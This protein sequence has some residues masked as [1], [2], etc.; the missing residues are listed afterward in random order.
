[1]TP[2]GVASAMVGQVVVLAH[3]KEEPHP[4][5]EPHDHE[6]H[7]DDEHGD[8][9]HGDDVTSNNSRTVYV[10]TDSGVVE[11]PD[12]VLRYASTGDIVQASISPQGALES[13]DVLVPGPDSGI[14][15]SD[16]IA[17]GKKRTVHTVVMSPP[18]VTVPA[19]AVTNAKNAVT[20]AGQYWSTQ[21]N[22][23]MS[24]VHGKVINGSGGLTGG[25]NRSQPWAAWT[26]AWDLFG[27]T[28]ADLNS[29]NNASHLL[30]V[31]HGCGEGSP[32]GTASMGDT[33]I[34]SGGKDFNL[35]YT[36]A[37]NGPQMGVIA[38]ELGHNF[39][40]EHANVLE[41]GSG[42]MDARTD[43]AWKHHSGRCVIREYGDML[44]VM[45]SSG[46]TNLGS[47]SAPAADYLGFS[48]GW[49]KVTPGSKPVTLTLT[50]TAESSGTRGVRVTDPVTGDKYWL[51][52]RNNAG[53]DKSLNGR[54]VSWGSRRFVTESGVRVMKAIRDNSGMCKGVVFPYCGTVY[55]ANPKAKID[56]SL[57]STSFGVDQ[58]MTSISEGFALR[59]NSMT[60]TTA[61]I[62]IGRSVPQPAI[63]AGTVKISG[64][65]AS[66]QTVT[67]KPS[68][69]A[70]L[71]NRHTL[72]YQWYRAGSAISGATSQK[73]V[74]K[75]ADKGKQITVRVRAT[76]ADHVS[77]PWVRSGA[78]LPNVIKKGKVTI[79][80]TPKV[81]SRL[82]MTR[83]GFT[84]NP[85]SYT[86]Q[87]RRNGQAIKGAKG[88]TYTL[89]AADRGKRITVTVTAKRSGFQA[90][91]VTSKKTA[92][93]K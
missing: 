67:A 36:V 11:V 4:G 56:A 82:T 35:S 69:F 33:A 65:Q 77:T 83:T 43:S 84:D 80:G 40:L 17:R 5:P 48:R 12:D 58:R 32:A 57:R 86:V 29:W 92:T 44:D 85:K 52:M 34:R 47:L 2:Q 25:C 62:T 49:V 76:R 7:G 90:R 10:M 39:G 70:S 64:T 6:E 46:K 22:G 18:G 72:A 19:S 73:Y 71:E 27:L 30:V 53:Y 13:L 88:K 1:M 79:S 9:A 61:T 16:V 93:V 23:T 20:Q 66:G 74:L 63:K 51:E 21:S 15:L 31:V 41:C 59:V 42:S 26:A 60:A 87:W 75:N 68:G 89:K 3:A 28:Q 54:V 14:A 24:F 37:W 38:H 8:D 55:V 81:G 50:A 78:I 45:S 91:E